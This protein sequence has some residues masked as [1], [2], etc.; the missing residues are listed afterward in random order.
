M[1]KADIMPVLMDVD[2]GTDDAIALMLACS[3]KNINILGVTTV[4]G[5]VSLENTTTN[6]LN[7][8]NHLGRK[9]IPVSMGADKPLVRNLTKASAIHGLNGL[10][11]KS[12][13]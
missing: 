7:V 5:N 11:R 4:G 8:L 1:K 6:T 9:D 12:V 13:V 2:T 10:D 3:A